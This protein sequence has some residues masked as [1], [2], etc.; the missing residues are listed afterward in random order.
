MSESECLSAL[1]ETRMVKRVVSLATMV[2]LLAGLVICWAIPSN[3]LGR[4]VSTALP[5]LLIV[6]AVVLL[7]RLSSRVL[8]EVG[9]EGGALLVRNRGRELRIPLRD[10]VQ[11]HASGLGARSTRITL[12][13]SHDTIFGNKLVFIPVARHF[14][15]PR[16]PEA[17]LY[18]LNESIDGTRKGAA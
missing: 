15:D 10:I 13:S 5:W 4:I 7:G 1:Q 12:R 11:V 2:V 16:R 17:V 14:F 6:A 9:L 18:G 3:P 8:D